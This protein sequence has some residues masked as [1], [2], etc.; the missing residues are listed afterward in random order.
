MTSELEQACEK[1]KITLTAWKSAHPPAWDGSKSWF[2][3]LHFEHNHMAGE[4]FTGSGV[5]D[6]PK[7][8][9]VLSCVLS[10]AAAYINASD[11]DDFAADTWDNQSGKGG[12][13]K[14]IAAFEACKRS[15]KD[16]EKLFRCRPSVLEEISNCEH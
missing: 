6:E 9:D 10:D 16:L 14:L 4:Y 15:Q 7:V 8:A 2:F 3:V 12:I 11:I 13:G 1:H 5:K